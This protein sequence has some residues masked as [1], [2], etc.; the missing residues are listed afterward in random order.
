MKN[1]FASP[2]QEKVR[3]LLENM[4]REFWPFD[5]CQGIVGQFCDCSCQGFLMGILS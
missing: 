4:Y 3:E 2:G 1:K 5:S